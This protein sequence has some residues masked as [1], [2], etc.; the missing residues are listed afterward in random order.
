MPD[1]RYRKR[2]GGEHLFLERDG[3]REEFQE[4]GV[5]GAESE[6]RGW[7]SVQGSGQE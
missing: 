6:R 5:V 3:M 4:N 1:E 7:I 2:G